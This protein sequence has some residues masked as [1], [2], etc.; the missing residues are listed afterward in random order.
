V[1]I[2]LLSFYYPPDL[3]AGSFRA[4]ALVQALLPKLPPGCDLELLTTAPNRYATFAGE[5]APAHEILPRLAIHRIP[6]PPH[7][8]G[9]ADQARAFT[10]YARTVLART[11]G[12]KYSLVYGTSSRLITAT[13][14]ALV[15]R[16]T[17]AP[18]YLDIRDIFVDTMKDVLPKLSGIVAKPL[19]SSL[20]KWTINSA[21][22]VNLVSGG[23]EEYFKTRFPAKSFSFFT[24]GIDPEFRSPA[25]FAST[26]PV[27]RNAPVVLYA[28]NM[29]EGQGLHAIVPD[30]AQRLGTSVRFRLIGDGGRK[31]QLLERLR[32]MACNNVEVIPP[33]NRERLRAEYRDADVLFLH[34]N[35]Y[36]AFRKVLP[37]KVF[38]YAAT[39]KPIWAGV[40][41]FS[42]NFIEKEIPNS[43]VFAPCRHDDALDAFR[44]LALRPV[45]RSAFV[46]KYARDVIMQEMATDILSVLA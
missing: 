22:R 34:L 5:A 35:D 17:G 26:A 37:S 13:L 8:S 23:F 4:S 6:L 41:G 7:R 28:G 25:E 11:R 14:A 19:L 45:D 9:M 38:E 20:E 2:L 30:L 3:C 24:N 44:R 16:R 40:A 18:L 29:G 39:G 33:L 12:Q 32:E 43:A 27:G 15:A 42:A 1:K 31:G 46:E 10:A 36:D 21:A